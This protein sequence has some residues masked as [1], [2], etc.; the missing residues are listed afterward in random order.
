MTLLELLRWF[1]SQNFVAIKTGVKGKKKVK[2]T[3]YPAMKAHNWSGAIAL[4]FL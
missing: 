3:L 4:L 2:F 1:L